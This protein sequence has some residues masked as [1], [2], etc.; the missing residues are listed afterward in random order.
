MT[1]KKIWYVEAT[2]HTNETIAAELTAHSADHVLHR[3][4]LCIDGKKRNFRE[5]SYAFITNLLANEANAQIKFEVF[6]RDGAHEP[7]RLWPFLRKR[8]MTLST[9]LKKGKVKKA[10]Y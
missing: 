5:C 9:A 7:V 10:F 3:D 2:G 6:C 1:T 8:R 4:V